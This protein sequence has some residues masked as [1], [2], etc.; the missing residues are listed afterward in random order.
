MLEMTPK[1]K[2]QRTKEVL[3]EGLTRKQAN[4][5]D[6]VLE[7]ARKEF[8]FRQKMLMENASA[9]AVTSGNIAVLNK[10]ILP[11]IRRVLPNVIANEIVGV[12]PMQGPVSQ[13]A[14]LRYVYGTTVAAAAAFSGQEAMTPLHIADLAVAYSGNEL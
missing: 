11:I 3:F 13:I 5:M 12:Q 1:S 10:V 8:V 9:A 4:V 7:N 6:K 14:T 2:W